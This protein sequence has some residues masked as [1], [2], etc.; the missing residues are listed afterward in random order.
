EGDLVLLEMNIDEWVEELLAGNRFIETETFNLTNPEAIKKSSK[1]RVIDTDPVWSPDGKFILFVTDK[2]SPGLPNLAFIDPKKP[3]DIRQ[4]TTDGAV[5]PSF[6]KDGD[7]VFFVS[8]KDEK[9]GEI[10]QLD[11]ISKVT[12]RI[13]EDTF[14]DFTPTVDSKGI[15]LYYSSIRKD[16]NANGLLDERDTNFLIMRNLL[17]GKERVLSSGEA[18]YFDIRY[19]AFNGGSIL[20]SAP[21]YNSINIYFIPE[22]GSIPKQESIAEQ[23]QYAKIFQENQNIESYLLGL[24]SIEL[25]FSEDPLY[26]IYLAKTKALKIAAFEK[27]GRSS[28]AKKIIQQMT[29]QSINPYSAYE[30]GLGKWISGNKNLRN[31][32]LDSFIHKLDETNVSIDTIPSLIHILIDDY[33]NTKDLINTAN[34]LRE[35]TSKFPKYHQASEMKRRLGGYEFAS[36][37]KTLPNVYKEIISNWKLESN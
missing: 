9:R 27:L 13:T 32:E 34:Y 33:E 30:I 23:Y 36:N 16:T 24:D 4:L 3:N 29:N 1:Q 21:F 15:F 26:P 31:N 12:S 5:N 10:Y 25:F 22:S 37:S 11:L 8:Y 17:T 18:S 7:K 35:I 28:D 6:S 20:F 19:S 2:F 14:L